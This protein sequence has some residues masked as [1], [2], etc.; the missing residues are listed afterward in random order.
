[1]RAA[2]H[3]QIGLSLIHHFRPFALT[4]KARKSLWSPDS[5]KF[6]AIEDV[7]RLDLDGR[8][9]TPWWSW[10]EFQLAGRS[11]WLGDPARTAAYLNAPPAILRMQD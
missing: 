7:E 4:M 1:M 11:G 10:L 3:L 8:E 2:R 6:E 5:K 9:F